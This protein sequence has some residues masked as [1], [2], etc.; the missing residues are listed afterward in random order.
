MFIDVWA[1]GRYRTRYIHLYDGLHPSVRLLQ[2][3]VGKILD[4]CCS[5]FPYASH[6][7]Q[8]VMYHYNEN[9]FGI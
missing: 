2:I 8:R 3:W 4:Y 5:Y 9:Q 6:V 1:G 7:Q